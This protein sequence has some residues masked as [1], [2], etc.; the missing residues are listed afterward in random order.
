[1]LGSVNRHI[2]PVLDSLD[3]SVFSGDAFLDAGNR[4]VFRAYMER[5]EKALKQF[6]SYGDDDDDG[7]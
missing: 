2:D 4:T 1:M 7:E 3:A 6:D 5:W